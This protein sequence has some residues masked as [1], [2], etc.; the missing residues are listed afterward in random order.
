MAT[1]TLGGFGTATG[2]TLYGVLRNSAGLLFA[3]TDDTF[4]AHTGSDG[5]HDIPLSADGDQPYYYTGSITIDNFPSAAGHYLL[6]IYLQ[7][8]GAPAFKAGTD[9]PI[10]TATLNWNGSA[11]EETSRLSAA[12]A[13]DAVWD[14]ERGDHTTD[15]TYG[16]QEGPNFVAHDWAYDSDGKPLGCVMTFYDTAANV[17]TGLGATGKLFTRTFAALTWSGGVPASSATSKVS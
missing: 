6:A 13:E 5:D 2:Q 1:D 10:R 15:G 11:F 12:E 16:L 7:A 14:A 9:S 17:D 3:T 8:G 4:K